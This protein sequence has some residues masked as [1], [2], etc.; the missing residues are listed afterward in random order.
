MTNIDEL[1]S[2]YR[3]AVAS[4]ESAKVTTARFRHA[5]DEANRL[6]AELIKLGVTADKL[7]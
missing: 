2:D 4:M 1:M 7:V 5:R 6:R 3:S